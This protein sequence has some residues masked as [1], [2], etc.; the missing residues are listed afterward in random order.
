M[1][2]Q[3]CRLCGDIVV[4]VC[5]QVRGDCMFIRICIVVGRLFLVHVE[6]CLVLLLSAPVLEASCIL[7]SS[8][9]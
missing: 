9:L 2:A 8:S 1:S 5:V 7:G 6:P 4:I 3:M